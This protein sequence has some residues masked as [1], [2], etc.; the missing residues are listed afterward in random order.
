MS[1]STS[2]RKGAEAEREVVRA[3]E[4]AGFAAMTSRAARGG[5]QHG[6]DLISDWP[7]EIEVKNQAKIDLP[8][9]WR[10]AQ[11]QAGDGL[12]GLVVKRRG[13]ARA[14]DWWYVMDLATAIELVRR[15]SER[16]EG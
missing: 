8:G 4:R 11:E 3:L 12:A 15:L 14:E 16:E 13:H 1:G 7:A 10:Q 5:T 6:A 2:R 9:F